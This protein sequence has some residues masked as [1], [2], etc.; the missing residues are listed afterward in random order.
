[1]LLPKRI[2][3][4]CLFW[5]NVNMMRINNRL[6]TFFLNPYF[7]FSQ[8]M[9]LFVAF[10]IGLPWPS[11]QIFQT[12]VNFKQEELNFT[13]RGSLNRFAMNSTTPNSGTSTQ[14][15]I[16]SN[17]RS[18]STHHSFLG[19]LLAKSDHMTYRGWVGSDELKVNSLST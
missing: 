3:L 18:E 14:T 2:L 10:R 13:C 1:M 7:R 15:L 17:E 6:F 16:L 12:D 4:P 8:K 11:F 5:K 9:F 19:F